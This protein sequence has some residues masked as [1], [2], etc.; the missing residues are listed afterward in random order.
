MQSI[1]AKEDMFVDH[2]DVK[3][4]F[5]YSDSDADVFM[6]QPH[7]FEGDPQVNEVWK[8]LGELY[9]LKQGS[10]LWGNRL[11]SDLISKGFTQMPTCP[12][13]KNNNNYII[14]R[15]KKCAR[16]LFFHPEKE[17]V[18]IVYVDD[19][20]VCAKTKEGLGFAKQI[21]RELYEITDLGKASWFLRIGIRQ[22][23]DGIS[24]T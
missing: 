11:S 12:C 9:G 2:V 18:L 15:V 5:L 21:L 20:I 3:E 13:Y 14:F 23:P 17:V 4:A 10:K 1:S 24:I 8:L 7:G 22:L 16:C 19:G 6:E